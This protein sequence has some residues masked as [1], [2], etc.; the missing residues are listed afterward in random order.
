MFG[1]EQAV[2]SKLIDSKPTDIDTDVERMVT[3]L[4]RCVSK[5][6]CKFCAKKFSY[7]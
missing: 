3:I 1:V 4:L 7:Q 2:L 6:V 5:V